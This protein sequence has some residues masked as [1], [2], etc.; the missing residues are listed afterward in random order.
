M[1]SELM[2]P[3]YN[4]KDVVSNKLI[5]TRTNKRSGKMRLAE[6]I[7]DFNEWLMVIAS[8]PRVATKKSTGRRAKSV[9]N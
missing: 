3:Y 4:W 8:L 6:M 7:G 2:K 5:S 9:N 1:E